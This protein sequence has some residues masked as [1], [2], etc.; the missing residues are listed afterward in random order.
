MTVKRE[1]EMLRE[2]VNSLQS[3]DRPD[4]S[5][6][7]EVSILECQHHWNTELKKGVAKRQN[8][9]EEYSNQLLEQAGKSCTMF[10]E[11]QNEKFRMWIQQMQNVQL[12]NE[13]MRQ[14]RLRHH[15]D[16][17]KLHYKV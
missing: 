11:Q 3:S 13:E 8:E 1:G 14:Q 17:N 4:Q 6:L 9:V 5:A 7:V 10:A 16:R 15:Q 2:N 12:E